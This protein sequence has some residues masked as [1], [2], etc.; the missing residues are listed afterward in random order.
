MLAAKNGLLYDDGG[1]LA[2][3]GSVNNSL[4]SELNQFSYYYQQA[5]KSLANSFGIST[6]YP[7]IERYG[8]SVEDALRTYT[9]HIAIQVA[10]SADQLNA[11]KGK[12]LVT[13]GGAFNTFLIKRL[14]ETMATRAIEI[15]VPNEELVQYKEA[16]IMALIGVLRWREEINVMASVTGA[17]RSS[18]GGALWMGDS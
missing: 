16:L 4:L 6:V 12:M 13:G 10:A 1:K 15:I 11:T 8:L 18:I 9:E 17:K 3:S 2:S 5:P 7:I 14:T